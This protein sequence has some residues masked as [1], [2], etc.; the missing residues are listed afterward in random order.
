VKTDEIAQIVFLPSGRPAPAVLTAEETAELLRLDGNSQR[1]L[2]YWRDIGELIGIRLGRKV[3]Y[4]LSDVL[5]FL[6]KK[7]ECRRP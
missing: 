2:K 6:N 4:R 1:A 5:D 3:R 7:A